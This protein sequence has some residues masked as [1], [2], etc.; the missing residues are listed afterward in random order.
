VG[1]AVTM[2]PGID[3]VVERS[4]WKT[5]VGYAPG[6]EHDEVGSLSLLHFDCGAGL[7]L[8]G[9]SCFRHTGNYTSPHLSFDFLTA[10]PFA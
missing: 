8:L 5:I 1:T 7:C 6:A 3:T 4:L 9:E 10:F 2:D